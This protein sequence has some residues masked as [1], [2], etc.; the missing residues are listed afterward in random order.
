MS[1]GLW[2][3]CVK[4]NVPQ[5]HDHESTVRL[6]MENAYCMLGPSIPFLSLY[7]LSLIVVKWKNTSKNA[8][9]LMLSDLNNLVV[10]WLI[11]LHAEVWNSRNSL[12]KRNTTISPCL[13]FVTWHRGVSAE[14]GWNSLVF[15]AFFP[16]IW[17]WV[18]HLI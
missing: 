13:W 3:D 17:R 10:K 7:V 16:W 6:W 11:S 9:P 2:N 18:Q 15:I 1:C 8:I 5:P 12:F 4:T 14:C